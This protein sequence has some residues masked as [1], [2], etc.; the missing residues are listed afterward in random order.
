M[1]ISFLANPTPLASGTLSTPIS[2]TEGVTSGGIT[3]G[4]GGQSV[5]IVAHDSNAQPQAGGGGQGNKPPGGTKPTVPPPD[6]PGGGR[7]TNPKDLYREGNA[8]EPRVGKLRPGREISDGGDEVCPNQRGISTFESITKAS[9]KWWKLPAG[10]ELPEGLQFRNDSGEH[11]G[12]EPTRPMSV[13]DYREL[14]KS[15]EG[16]EPCF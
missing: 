2:T 7:K 14:L 1:I 16:W 5:N 12:I 10:T 9:G 3:P 4:P 15:I 6:N 8:T 13:E 11:W